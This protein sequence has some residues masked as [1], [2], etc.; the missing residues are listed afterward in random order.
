MKKAHM[1]EGKQED[2][3]EKLFKKVAFEE[4]PDSFS[5]SSGSDVSQDEFQD[6]VLQQ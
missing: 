2:E 4:T 1:W 5:V 6:A 3:V